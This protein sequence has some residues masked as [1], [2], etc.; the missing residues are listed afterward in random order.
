MTKLLQSNIG[1]VARK[2]AKNSLDSLDD[3]YVYLV[4]KQFIGDRS[5]RFNA[6]DARR[7][8]RA[9][10]KLWQLTELSATGFADEAARFFALPRISLPELIAAPSLIEAFRPGFCGNPPSSL[11]QQRK[12]SHGW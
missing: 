12:V 5:S 10:Q 6:A 4:G 3:F 2:E 8:G 9:L 1:A 11:M 7:S